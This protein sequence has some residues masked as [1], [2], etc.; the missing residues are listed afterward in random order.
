MTVTATKKLA[1]STIATVDAA[2]TQ[3][4]EA[5]SREEIDPTEVTVVVDAL[6]DLRSA[7]TLV[8]HPRGEN[9]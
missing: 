7:C 5:F 3:W 8:T 9:A 1:K 4:Q 6:L 2:L